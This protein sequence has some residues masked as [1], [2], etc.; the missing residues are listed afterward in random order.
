MLGASAMLPLPASSGLKWVVVRAS[1]P[2][3][4]LPLVS[5]YTNEF[6]H[7]RVAWDVK[8][9]R[10]KMGRITIVDGKRVGKVVFPDSKYNE[11][12]VILKTVY[13]TRHLVSCGDDPL[14]PQVGP[15]CDIAGIA[16]SPTDVRKLVGQNKI[17]IVLGTETDDP[18]GRLRQPSPPFLTRLT[19][20]PTHA[21]MLLSGPRSTLD[22]SP[23]RVWHVD[24]GN[25]DAV[26]ALRTGDE[27]CPGASG[28]SSRSG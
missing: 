10:G 28:R 17:A 23:S 26:M 25:D 12:L 9:F 13:S 14:F 8:D 24:F 18:S 15:L 6:M 27:A 19:Q 11:W 3:E 5:S 2:A 22:S 4:D 1:A 21:S 7:R 20:R 16:Y